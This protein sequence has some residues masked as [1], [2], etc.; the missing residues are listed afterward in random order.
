M[1]TMR[2]LIAA[3]MV[4]GLFGI[5]VAKLPPAPPL[6]EEQKA[7][8]AAKA[9]AE[10]EKAGRKAKAEEK[11]AERKPHS[12]GRHDLTADL[13]DESIEDNATYKPY[14]VT[15]LRQDSGAWGAAGAEEPGEPRTERRVSGA[16]GTA[17]V[18]G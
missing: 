4:V 5:A 3:A 14:A 9:K 8:K 12:R 6:T 13:D 7:E 10:E 1:K 16:P 17:E 15:L 2:A 18:G 11:K